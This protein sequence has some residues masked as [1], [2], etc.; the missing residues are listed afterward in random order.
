M[1]DLFKLRRD[2]AAV[3][4]SVAAFKEEE[5]VLNRVFNAPVGLVWDAWTETSLVP[6]WWGP[7]HCSSSIEKMDLREG[8][9][10]LKCVRTPGNLE[11]WSK[12]V[13]TEIVEYKSLVMTDALS[14]KDGRPV[15][16]SR[17]GLPDDWP[18]ELLIS[19]TFA[20]LGGGRTRLTLRHSDLAGIRAE[21]R[22]DLKLGW[23]QSFD[24]L[25]ELL[26]RLVQPSA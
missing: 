9:R 11:F 4:E 7:K 6:G 22:S 2:G 20:I 8:G 12:G 26:A 16:P 19:V 13:F 3:L 24:K 14:D 15:P 10:Y 1:I 5:I 23:Q 25:E 17:Y 21:D 18:D